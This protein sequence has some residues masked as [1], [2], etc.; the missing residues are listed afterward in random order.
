MKTQPSQMMRP[1]EA[2]L[3]RSGTKSFWLWTPARQWLWALIAAAMILVMPP[4]VS[5]AKDPKTPAKSDK[6]KPGKPIVLPKS[7]Q[8][9]AALRKT[10][11]SEPTII[12]GKIE[13]GLTLKGLVVIAKDAELLN[14]T[15]E[16]TPSSGA[17]VV[18]NAEAVYYK[19]ARI[20]GIP[21]VSISTNPKAAQKSHFYTTSQ[22]W[23]TP[24]ENCIFQGNFYLESGCSPDFNN[25]LFIGS[26]LPGCNGLRA[27]NAEPVKG[28]YVNCLFQ[29]FTFTNL[30]HVAMT[31]NIAENCG[32]KDIKIAKPPPAEVSLWGGTKQSPFYDL[33]GTLAA[34]LSQ[35]KYKNEPAPK[36]PAIAKPEKNSLPYADKAA[37]IIGVL[38]EI[39]QKHQD[40][41]PNIKPAKPE[42]GQ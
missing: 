1:T 22:Y 37:E 28:K 7:D 20:S 3:V 18:N 24:Y 23:G 8:V 34:P 9:L 10:A 13:K 14:D 33:D 38:D 41:N 32:F 25:C 26:S 11:E 15:I 30:S 4:Y 5:F 36:F 6:Q 42:A 31:L 39:A 12:R 21:F 40:V 19:P 16:L 29:G 2:S 27:G 35:L 17:I